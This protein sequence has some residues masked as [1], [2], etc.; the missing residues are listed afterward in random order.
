MLTNTKKS[1][2]MWL[3][4]PVALFFAGTASAGGIWD[5]EKELQL[6]RD[7]KVQQHIGKARYR[8]AVFTFDD[9][10]GTGLGN[11]VASILSHDLLMNSKVS[12]IGV[13]RYVGNLGKA[14]ED[15]QLRYFDKVEPLI[16]SQGVQVAIWG[17]IRRRGEL[18]RIDSF[19]QLSP[20]VMRSAFSFSFSM[21]VEIGSGRLVHRI[22]PDRM[23]TQRLELSSEQA[24]YLAPIAVDLDRLRATPNGSAPFVGQ[25]PLGSVYYL[26]RRQGEWIQVGMQSGQSGWLRSTGFC[27]GTCAPLLSVSRFASELMA[28]DDRASLPERSERL[29]P[30]AKAFIDQLW[31]VEVLNGAPAQY[32]EQEALYR[33]NP[34]CP[35]RDEAAF[36]DHAPPPGGAAICNLRAIT[37][38]V[39]MSRKAARQQLQDGQL[40]EDTMRSVADELAMVSMSDPRHVPTLKNLATLFGFLGD[41]ER[42]KLAARLADEAA[43]AVLVPAY[44]AA[45]PPEPQAQPLK[46]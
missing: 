15:K 14:G 32:A 40:K 33:L 25:L 11:A 41:A 16:E 22:G 4:A 27:T 13:L 38:L 44:D 23:L 37:R 17:T 12:S 19:M 43:S 35:A 30:D 46:P 1:F 21:P 36:E 6:L 18:V 20:S 29:A 2:W 28:Y 39:G 9:P 5:I 42:A 7:G 3:V 31:A 10:D 45:P 24:S 34:W 8:F 26:Q